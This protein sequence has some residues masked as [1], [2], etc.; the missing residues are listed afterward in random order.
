MGEHLTPKRI[1]S[2]A[3]CCRQLSVHRLSGYCIYS[4]IIRREAWKGW[5]GAGK[6]K[7]QRCCWLAR[8]TSLSESEND[9]W[10]LCF[11]HFAHH[12]P[13]P[14]HL[15]TPK[16]SVR[17]RGDKRSNERRGKQRTVTAGR[18]CKFHQRIYSF[19]C[20]CALHFFFVCSICHV[21]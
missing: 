2:P 9:C 4:L 20:V 21:K 17:T 8:H 18:A 5:T 10:D 19:V 13:Q 16:P 1:S 3:A 14:L 15:D 7:S 11:T 6:Q 12:P